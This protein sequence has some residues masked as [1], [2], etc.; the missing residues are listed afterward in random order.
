[1]TIEEFEALPEGTKLY[2]KEGF[3]DGEDTFVIGMYIKADNL[4]AVQKLAGGKPVGGRLG[5]LNEDMY[6][7]KIIKGRKGLIMTV[8]KFEALPEGTK[9]RLKKGYIDTYEDT[10][11]AGEY[12]KLD[13]RDEVQRLIDGK[14]V[15]YRLGVLD[16]DMHRF[17]VVEEERGCRMKKFEGESKLVKAGTLKVG[18]TFISEGD[19]FLILGQGKYTKQ[20]IEAVVKVDPN[21]IIPTVMLSTGECY[22]T[23]VSVLVEPVSIEYKVL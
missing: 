14:P 18:A 23:G 6:R 17:E 2:L 21:V 8:R 20:A 5:V 19:E 10:F 9:L 11:E 12:V 22:N 7:F 13:F 4:D 15:G 16:A 3:T 1:M